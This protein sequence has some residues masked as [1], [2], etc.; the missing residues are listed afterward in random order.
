MLGLATFLP[1][2]MGIGMV[3]P[4]RA[5]FALLSLLLSSCANPATDPRIDEAP[6]NDE[7]RGQAKAYFSKPNAKAFA[8]EPETGTNWH[9]WGHSSVEETQRIALSTCVEKSDSAVNIVRGQP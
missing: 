9:A 8:F 1:A 2:G 7:S 6:M 5:Q 4:G 3:I